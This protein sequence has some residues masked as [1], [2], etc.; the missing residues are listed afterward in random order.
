MERI[1]TVLHN[2]EKNQARKSVGDLTRWLKKKGYGV[3]TKLS[4]R[5]LPLSQFAIAL[6]G[7]GTILRVSRRLA[8]LG[9]PI[10]GINLGRLGFLVETDFK[11]L[12]PTLRKALRSKLKIE[13]HLMLRVSLLRRNK[14]IFGS[15]SLNDCYLHAGSSARVIDI[16]TFLNGEFLAE[17]TG[18]GVIVST[19]TGSTAYSMAA[20]G[21]IVYPELP[22]ILLTPICP[23]TLAQRPLLVSSKDKLELIIKNC[24]ARQFIF[25]SIDGQEII[26][27]REGDRILVEAALRKMKLLVN[28]EKSYYQILRTKLRWGERY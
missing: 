4:D 8:P 25:L 2:P 22:V 15:L 11:D 16:E 23:H 5:R 28:P 7:D 17:Y 6:G 24:P 20:S 9:I 19:P 12:F 21:P 10:L 3:V 18:D 14:K 13:E 26:K 27:V 1:I